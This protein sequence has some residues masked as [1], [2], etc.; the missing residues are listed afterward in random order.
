MPRFIADD[1]TPIAYH[2]TG[3]AKPPVLFIHG[4]TSGGLHWGGVMLAL[5]RWYRCVA[6]DLRGHGRTPARGELSIAR[7]AADVEGLIRHLGLERPTLVG[8]SMGGLATFEYLRQFGH[9]HLGG[10]VFVDQ[11]PRVRTDA[12]WEL[13]LFGA[14]TDAHIAN[15]DELFA[16]QTRR[17]I[18]RFSMGIVHPRRRL[19]R[20]A[21]WLIAPYRVR[22]APETLRALAHNMADLD[23]RDLLPELDVPVLL[24]YG[25]KSWLYPGAVGEYLR[26]RLPRAELVKF[27]RS[28]HC[29]PIEEPLKFV[30]ALRSFLDARR[31]AGAAA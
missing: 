23:Y 19:L 1:Q 26:E 31:P 7:M 11:T 29:P 3:G 4:W 6:I 22:V 15:F 2:D 20:F 16:T 12:E 5:S 25:A 10:V 8:H 28:G 21:S 27:E 30:R 17:L 9:A 13:G 18:R 24:C 14:Y